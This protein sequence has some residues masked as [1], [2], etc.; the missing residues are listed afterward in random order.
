MVVAGVMVVVLVVGDEVGDSQKG[1][2]KGCDRSWRCNNID[3][4]NGC[5]DTCSCTPNY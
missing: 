4:D 5:N 1:L 3:D 2:L